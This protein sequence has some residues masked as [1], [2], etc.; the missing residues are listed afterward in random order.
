MICKLCGLDKK[1]IR[2][3]VIPRSF[4]RIDPA[5]KTPTRL[6]TNVAGRYAQKTPIGVY[7]DTIVCEDCEHRFTKWDEY[8][9][10]LFL[11]SWDKFAPIIHRNEEVGYGLNAYDY[12][13]LKMFFLSVLWRAS[14]SSHPM[15]SNIELGAREVILKQ[16]IWNSDPGDIDHFGV[17]LQ[18]FDST[19]VGI[20]NPHPERFSGVRYCRFYI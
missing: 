6:V 4:Y 3:H 5:E 17:V 12:S 2:A 20:L 16:A 8:G 7:D 9:D 1:L 19:D 14:V 11:K 13:K 18:A 10:E 15:F